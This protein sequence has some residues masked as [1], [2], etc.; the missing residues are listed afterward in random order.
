MWNSS[1]SCN[2]HDLVSALL[3]SSFLWPFGSR[4]T[5]R[6]TLGDFL[7]VRCDEK[8]ISLRL[9]LLSPSCWLVVSI[10]KRKS[11]YIFCGI[12]SSVYCI[13]VTYGLY[14]KNKIT[15]K[16]W[17][18]SAGCFRRRGSCREQGSVE[19]VLLFK[20]STILLMSDCEEEFDD[21]PTENLNKRAE[22]IVGAF[23]AEWTDQ[24]TA[25]SGITTQI[26]P[27]FDGSTSWFK[28]EELIDDWLDL[29]VLQERK[30][31]QTLK[32]RLVG[33]AE[34][35]I[36][37]SIENLWGQKMAS[38]FFGIRWDPI[39]SRALRV[40][41]SRD[42]INSFEQGVE[43]LRL[44]S[45]SASFLYSWT[46]FKD[47]WMDML[48]LSAMSQEQR[49]SQ[50]MTNMTSKNAEWQSRNEA[51][52]D[53]AQQGTGD[54][55]YTTHVT[56][57]ER[58]FPF[59][60]N[61]TTVMFI[62]AG[63]PR[64]AQRERLTS[65]LFSQVNVTDYTL[66]AVKTVFCRIILFAGKLN[67]E[68]FSPRAWTMGFWRSNWWARLHWWWKI[69]FLDM[70]RQRASLAVQ[71][72]LKVAKLKEEKG[73]GKGWFK[74]TGRAHFGE[75]QT[76]EIEWWSEE[77]SVQEKRVDEQPNKRSKKKWWQK[78]CS[79][80]E[81][82]TTI[83][84]RISGCG[85]AEILRCVQFTKADVRHAD[86]RDQ[87]QSLG[88]IC[89]GDPHQRNPNA[90]KF[91]DRSQEETAWQERWAREAAW[92]LAKNIPKL[93]EKH[94]STFLS[95]TR[96]RCPPAFSKIKPEERE[97]V[98]DSGA[99]MHMISRKYLNSAE[100]ETVRIS[101]SPT[102]VMTVNG[103]VQTN[104]E[105]TVYVKELDLFLTVKLLEDTPAVLSLGKLCEDHGYS[106][107]WTSGHKPHLI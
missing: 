1:I 52:L 78:C 40:F 93:E 100:V 56:T 31:G 92:R 103:D 55:W 61:L 5:G 99:S 84:L 69:V 101:K 17:L 104:E 27:L 79:Y 21:F 63:D 2:K 54:T 6:N 58:L 81:G 71:T 3:L 94:T 86:I 30:R 7:H 14:R 46:V 64:E 23:R 88:M 19:W 53:S 32:N 16:T 51:L 59:N 60:D 37:F 68:S 107:E 11:R 96:D 10:Q 62:V 50:K 36:D 43:T 87:N 29:T 89:P 47:A 80:I 75:E 4:P 35:H 85:A 76:Q 18:R 48:P 44:T 97:F 82:Y 39:S 28:Y 98:V 91:E 77:E 57:H 22:S 13:L 33:D 9:S 67:G 45:W 20:V 102:T 83:G 15:T 72:F 90:P 8:G 70:G 41:S 74:G 49:Y 34:M 25:A 73:K 24:W 95:P 66:E 105:A 106:Y 42:S 26:Q 38:S 12:L 65:S